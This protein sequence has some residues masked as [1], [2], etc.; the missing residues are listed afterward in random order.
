MNENLSTFFAW[1]PIRVQTWRGTYAS[2]W[3]Q[4]YYEQ[5]GVKYC[6]YINW[7]GVED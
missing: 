1:L 4:E 3:L 5:H 2:I 7:L 6:L